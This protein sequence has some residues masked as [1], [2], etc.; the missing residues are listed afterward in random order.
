[1]RTGTALLRRLP[2]NMAHRVAI[3]ALKHRLTPTDREPD[4]PVLATRLWGMDFSNPIGMAAGFDKDAEALDGLIASGFGFAEAGTVTP[5]PQPGNPRPNLFR[6]PEDRALINRLGFPSRGLDRLAQNLANRERSGAIV[7]VNVGINTGTDDAIRD[8]TAGISRLANDASYLVINVSCPNTPGLCVWQER[9]HLRPLLDGAI[10]A[11]DAAHAETPMLVKIS[12][13]LDDEGLEAV[14]EISL[15]AGIDGLIA[16]NTTT[17]RPAS[18][19]GADAQQTGG[20]SGPPLAA[21]ATEALSK[22]YRLTGGKIPLIGCGGISSA[23]D[24]YA[25]IRAG[26]TL[27]QIYTAL[28]YGGPGLVRE[29]KDGLAA[30]LI[31]DGFASVSDAVGVDCRQS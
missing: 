13:D 9:E 12:P 29:I 25:R 3:L 17:V 18:L 30:L 15:A 16:A 10:A 14:V 2:P 31:A 19:R 22:L 6:L 4:A 8:I 24:A 11:R 28:V 21:P 27:V 23:R 5:L 20:L 7:G 1:L 26:A